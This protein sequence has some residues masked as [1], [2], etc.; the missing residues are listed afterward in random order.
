[1]K[2]DEDEV[3]G[4]H[5][6]LRM[7]SVVG[8]L[9]RYRWLIVGTTVV[10][11]VATVAFAILS[12]ALPADQSPLPN[13]YRANAKLLLAEGTGVDTSVAVLS[14][15][16]I[17]AP[18]S[19]TIDYGRIAL[20]V[21]ESRSFVD[22]I[23]EE[24]DLVERY[25]ITENV[26]SASREAYL[27]NA[28]FSYNLEKGVLTLGYTAVDRELAY[29]VTLSMVEQ[30]Q[31]WFQS[32]GGLSRM[33]TLE[34]LEEKALEVEQ[35]IVT[36]QNR[37][38]AFQEEHGALTVEEIA[39]RQS[40]LLNNLYTQ[41]VELDV[42]I[43]NQRAL[44]RIE[45]DPALAR[46]QVERNNVAQQIAEIERG[47]SGSGESLPSRDEL[48]ELAL[49]FSRLQT[50]L[51]IQERIYKAVTEQYEVARLTSDSA[52]AFTVLEEPE[53]PDRKE[54]PSRGRLVISVTLGTFIAS[55]LL[56]FLVDWTRAFFRDDETRD[57]ILSGLNGEADRSTPGES[58]GG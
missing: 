19:S 33:Q 17:A 50:D 23:V 12:L 38:R 4:Q 42:R 13:Y 27:A 36:L 7:S 48:P 30:L 47:Y 22:R 1:M 45:N 5:L 31:S 56:A 46:L 34:S 52:A 57:V 3:S 2:H 9:F 21:L 8:T 32:R 20:D 37:I 49:R 54:G 25:G 41:L 44:A 28:D 24:H 40:A 51:E 16:G 55:C 39:E 26:R 11:A 10:A 43:R 18:R 29:R 35:E 15:L 58:G 14:A 6:L 53:V